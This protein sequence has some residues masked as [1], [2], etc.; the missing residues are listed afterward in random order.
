M[1]EVPEYLLERSRQ[2]R[3]ELTGASP[4]GGAAPA[5]EA[6]AS[7]AAPAPAA[8][9]P[10]PA[11]PAPVPEAAPPPPPEPDPPYVEA[12]NRRKRMPY[13]A[14]SVMVFLP[15]WAIFYVGM[16]EPPDSD[17]LVLADNGAAVYST[18]ASCHGADGSGTATGRQLNGG[19]LLL[20]FGSTPDFDGLAHHL[21]WVYL[22]T[23]GTKRLGLDFYGD[24]NRPDGQREVDSFASGMSGFSNLSLEDLVSVVYY[25]RVV[26]GG[27]DAEKAAHEEEML[28]ALVA[29][30]PTFETG[31]PDEISALLTESAEGHGID[32]AAGE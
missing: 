17:E 8:A 7:S 26:H 9:T 28:L 14:A 15:V 3:T 11:A 22:G 12:A 24:P 21:S 10:V 27:L 13:W 6:E 2:R 23:A 5:A 18:C 16:L 19:E 1:V 25:E 31:S 29:D 20:T 32:L 4:E 30:A